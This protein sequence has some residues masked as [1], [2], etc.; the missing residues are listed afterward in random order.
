MA[1]I[2]IVDDDEMTSMALAQVMRGEGHVVHAE[3]TLARGRATAAATPVDIVFL[4]VLLPDGNGLEWLPRFTALPAN[5]L[6]VIITTAG[7]PNGAE[8][9]IRNGAWDYVQKPCS[10][11]MVQLTLRQALAYRE[12]SLEPQP[13]ERGLIVGSSPQLAKCIKE[14]SLA[15]RSHVNV[16]VYGE[17]GVGKDLFVKALHQNSTVLNGPFVTVDCSALHPT[18]AVSELF[19]HKK[20]SFTSA[21]STNQG[22]VQQAHGGTLFLDEIS[23]LD[24]ETQKLLLR[25]LETRQFRPLGEHREAL[26]DFRC[27]CASNKD[28]AAQVEQGMFRKDLFFRIREATIHLPPL[29][30]RLSD[31]PELVAF[32]L[33]R[34]CKQNKL[35]M[36]TV[37]P[38]LMRMFCAY[39]ACPVNGKPNA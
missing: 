36:K 9:A 31:V 32:F 7:D 8:L 29:R 14:M 1:R 16:L 26:S 37:D 6:V 28:L 17:T 21:V 25:V 12:K 11:E 13:V 35:A 5:P 10:D 20:G 22:L 18:I 27:V 15:A 24:L 3:S 33:A 4:D 23:E 2:L 30:D 34:A 39:R 19:G 38:D